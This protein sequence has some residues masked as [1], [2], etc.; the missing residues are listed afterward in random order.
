M[1]SNIASQVLRPWTW[2][3]RSKAPERDVSA[4]VATRVVSKPVPSAVDPAAPGKLSEGQRHTILAELRNKIKTRFPGL[5][6]EAA[7]T[8]MR[9]D[10]ESLGRYL[11]VTYW[12][13]EVKVAERFS[14]CVRVEVHTG[15]SYAVSLMYHGCSKWHDTFGAAA[16]DRLRVGATWRPWWLKRRLGGQKI[17]LE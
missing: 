4:P 10:D 9:L 6:V 13:L 15:K 16:C 3:R 2:F 12:K 8:G 17:R 11:A 14:A 7:A 1:L 5:N